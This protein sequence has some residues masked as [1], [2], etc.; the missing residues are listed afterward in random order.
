MTPQSTRD[1]Y[2]INNNKA[3]LFETTILKNMSIGY[4]G[5]KLVSD[6]DVFA[7]LSERFENTLHEGN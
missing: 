2:S 6:S 7:L 4:T 3:F 1:R 5:M